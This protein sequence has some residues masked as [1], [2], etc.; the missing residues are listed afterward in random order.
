MLFTAAV[1]P[2]SQPQ[3]MAV[4]AATID[5]RLNG[6]NATGWFLLSRMIVEGKRS[7][8]FPYKIG[9]D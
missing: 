2:L 6:S 7:S 8:P 4:T 9:K 1:T 5:R 3:A